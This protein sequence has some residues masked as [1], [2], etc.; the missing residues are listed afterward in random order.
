MSVFILRTESDTES[1]S[2]FLAE[3]LVEAEDEEDFTMSSAKIQNAIFGLVVV[4]ALV[5]N[6]LPY[7]LLVGIDVSQEHANLTIG[8]CYMFSFFAIS[9]IGAY[10]AVRYAFSK[11]LRKF[12]VDNLGKKAIDDAI[13]RLKGKA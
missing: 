3:Y 5:A 7:K 1:A 2:E 6:S 4:S 10:V 11:G 12:G 13:A 8:A 9:S